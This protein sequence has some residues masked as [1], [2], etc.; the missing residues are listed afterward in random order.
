MVDLDLYRVFCVVAREGSL[1]RAAE[2]LHIT[3]SAVSQAVKQLES[4]LDTTLFLRRHKG[5][6]LT[7]IGR[8]V[9]D[10][11]QKGVT[12]LDG[13]QSI[14]ESRSDRD[15]GTKPHIAEN[16]IKR[17]WYCGTERRECGVWRY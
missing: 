12:L 2:K 17:F 9:I 13:V 7:P 8:M 11:A 15:N 5:M 3:Q 6:E 14:V 4:Q 16:G 1:T 10:D